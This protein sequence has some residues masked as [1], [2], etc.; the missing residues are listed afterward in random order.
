MELKRLPEQILN[1]KPGGRKT[2]AGQGRDDA[3]V[4]NRLKDV[5]PGHRR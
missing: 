5:I 2:L 3:Q 1:N 4:P